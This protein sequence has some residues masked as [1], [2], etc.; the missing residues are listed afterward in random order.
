ML[1]YQYYKQIPY[2]NRFVSLFCG[3]LIFI[4]FWVSINALL[5]KLL[6]VNGHLV[7]IFIGIPFITLLVINLREKRIEGLMM[8]N[9]DKLKI[10][11]D[12]LIQVH[13]MT[14]FSRGIEKD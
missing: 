12:S 3:S 9:I 4:Y 14:D 10:D 7:I 5:M 11:I 6:V 8:T 13:N 1:C 2:Y